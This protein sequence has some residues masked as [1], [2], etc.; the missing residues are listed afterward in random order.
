MQKQPSHVM[1]ATL[2]RKCDAESV[3]KKNKKRSGEL[4][5]RNLIKRK[6][7]RKKEL[8]MQAFSCFVLICGWHSI[9]KNERDET[10]EVRQKYS[11]V[12]GDKV[13]DGKKRRKEKLNRV[14]RERKSVTKSVIIQLNCRKHRKY[15]YTNNLLRC[16]EKKE[17]RM[18]LCALQKVIIDL[19]IRCKLHTSPSFSAHNHQKTILEKKNKKYNDY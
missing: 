17:K 2:E 19:I 18:T 4:R 12:W 14:I 10:R 6:N 3:W 5:C 13:A 11:S 7:I 15:K 16:Q 8:L 9:H 1:A